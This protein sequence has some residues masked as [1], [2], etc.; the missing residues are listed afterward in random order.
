MPEFRGQD[1]VSNINFILSPEFIPPPGRTGRHS[2]Q[3]LQKV[4]GEFICRQ[5]FVF[6][7][8]GRKLVVSIVDPPPRDVNAKSGHAAAL[9]SKGQ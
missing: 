2:V 3:L 7:A 4:F 5:S 1:K 6:S 8:G 9:R